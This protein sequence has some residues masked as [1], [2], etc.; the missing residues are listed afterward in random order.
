MNLKNKCEAELRDKERQAMESAKIRDTQKEE[1]EK[2]QL[3]NLH[4]KNEI[5]QNRIELMNQVKTH[6]D[7]LDKWRRKI[8]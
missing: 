4:L 3:E 7:E 1:K 6:S 2:L 5:S 8:T